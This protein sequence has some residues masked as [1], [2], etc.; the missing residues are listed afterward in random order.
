MVIPEHTAV[1]V[2]G[3]CYPVRIEADPIDGGFVAFSENAPRCGSQGETREE[4]LANIADAINESL[5]GRL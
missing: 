4:A 2:N 5:L 1:M 3:K